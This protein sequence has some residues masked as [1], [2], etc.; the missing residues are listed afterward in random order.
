MKHAPHATPDAQ[1]VVSRARSDGSVIRRLG[2]ILLVTNSL[3]C[4]IGRRECATEAEAR[5][6]FGRWTY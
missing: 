4:D 5:R 6:V 1:H 2:R 3:G